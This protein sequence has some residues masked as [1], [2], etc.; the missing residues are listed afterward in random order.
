[1]LPLKF[2]NITTDKIKLKPEALKAKDLRKFLLL[3]GIKKIREI[4]I[5]KIKKI[6][7]NKKY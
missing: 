6:E 2:I 5:I 1:V 7:L 3:D 4:A